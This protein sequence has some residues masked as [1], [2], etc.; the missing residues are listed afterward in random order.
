MKLITKN[1]KASFEYIFIEQYSAGIKLLGS[2]VKSIRNHDVSIS[3]GYCYFLDDELYIKGM[4]IKE[5]KVCGVNNHAPLRDRK[6]LL[7]KKEI[8]K[9]KVALQ[10]KGLTL[11]PTSLVINDR[12]FIK[13]EIALS[14]GKKLY[15]KRESLKAKDLDREQRV[16]E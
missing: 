11:I 7:N 5:Y 15:D 8:N 12:G 2:E 14:K 6:L 9:L 10:T 13:L 3:E 4:H 1:R 16:I